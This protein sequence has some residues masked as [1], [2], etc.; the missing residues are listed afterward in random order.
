MTKMV[1]AAL[2]SAGGKVVLATSSDEKHTP[3]NIID[4]RT[5][6]FWMT[7]GMF[8]QQFIISFSNPIKINTVTIQC[9]NVRCLSIEKSAST[10]VA[11]FEKC[12]EKE[13]Q[14]VEGQL[15]T[16]EFALS[17]IR[18]THLRFTIKSGF[19]HFVSVHRVM[20]EGSAS[21]I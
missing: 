20:V 7:T 15:Q 11:N 10:E 3:E 1:D 21:N 4:G 5:D 9:Y 13:L 18:A 17:Q 16:E 2:S 6:T 8:P 19:D 14:H 12:T